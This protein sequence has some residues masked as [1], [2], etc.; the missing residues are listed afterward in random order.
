MAF[1][2][3]RLTPSKTHN[4]IAW[5][6]VALCTIWVIVSIFLVIVN[7]ELQQPWA[8]IAGQ[9]SNMVC[10]L[11]LEVGSSLTVYKFTRWQFITALD[12]V[13]EIMLV[14]L[15]VFLVHDLRMS[16]GRKGVVVIAFLFRLPYSNPF[17]PHS[18]CRSANGTFRLI[19]FA[20]LHLHSS[21]TESSLSILALIWWDRL[22]GHRSS[23]I[24]ATS[25]RQYLSQTF[26]GSCQHQL[27]RD[28][29]CCN[30]PGRQS[31]L[32]IVKRQT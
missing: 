27:W 19:A 25:R 11:L 17:R 21:R 30:E 14:G 16:F 8:D 29:A 18:T 3:L 20:A 2:F 6:T 26:H 4:K 10:A 12:I 1:L 31:R 23:S 24:T 13:V 22:C 15:A 7:C 9:C 32:W 5:G 28:R